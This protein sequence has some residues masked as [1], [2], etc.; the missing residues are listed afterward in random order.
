MR[1]SFAILV[2]G[3]GRA[4]LGTLISLAQTEQNGDFF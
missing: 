1:E 2:L 4:P 3:L